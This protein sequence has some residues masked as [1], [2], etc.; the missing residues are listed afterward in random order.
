MKFF[1]TLL[2][3]VFGFF[4]QAQEVEV[5]GTVYKV[6]GESIFK[7]KVN[8]SETLTMEEKNNIRT[9][10]DEKIRL[11]KETKLKDSAIKKAEKEQKKAENKH[12]SAEKALKKKEK[13]HADFE[14]TGKKY[15]DAIKKYEKLKDKGKLSPEDEGKWLKKIDNYKEAIEKAKKKL[16]KA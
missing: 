9:N 10:L 5:N 3:L 15:E 12:K 14:K 11:E 6:K 8:V 2:C 13:A 7:D 16:K 1:I 4:V